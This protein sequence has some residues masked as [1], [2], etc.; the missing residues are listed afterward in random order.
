[1]DEA[2]AELLSRYLDGDLDADETRSLELRLAASPELQLE[3]AAL[4]RLQ[5]EVRSV[6]ERMQLPAE[7]ESPPRPLA[8][9]SPARPPA[10]I[11]PA[12]RWLGLAAGV[13]LAVTVA[14]EVSRRPP[15]P[16][17]AP[18]AGPAAA[19]AQVPPAAPRLEVLEAEPPAPADELA[20]GEALAPTE[21]S[22]SAPVPAPSRLPPP[23]PQAP[24][25]VVATTT[26][27]ANGRDAA[28]ASESLAEVDAAR[29]GS[30]PEARSAG[31]EATDT[32]ARDHE[33]EQSKAATKPAAFAGVTAGEVR[34]EGVA[35]AR[36]ELIGEDGSRVA[37]L[38]LPTA[39]PPLASRVVVT[40]SGGVI[41]TIEPAQ[42]EAALGA[43]IGRRVSGVG[44]GR[45][46]GVVVGRDPAP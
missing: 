34:Q 7:L 6:A 42:A 16:P 29:S 5:L 38:A 27:A 23:E 37:T 1:M 46:L 35:E 39:P 13:A 15:T 32:V 45:Y 19:P 18:D 21:A 30:A 40:V 3:L 31:A 20:K 14:L 28:A 10:R 25:L 44:D 24:A 4:R 26:T 9:P 41:A 33:Q 36:L 17:P 8:A 12:V 2:T 11:P 43:L 22:R